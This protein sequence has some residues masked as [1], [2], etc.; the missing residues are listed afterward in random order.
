MFQSRQLHKGIITDVS[1]PIVLEVPE[2]VHAHVGRG[3]SVTILQVPSRHPLSLP[4]SLAFHVR[5]SQ[6]FQGREEGDQL[7]ALQVTVMK[8]K[9][10]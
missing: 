3:R 10:A 9:Q 6:C 2:N 4:L 7:I 8:D 1:D 5:S